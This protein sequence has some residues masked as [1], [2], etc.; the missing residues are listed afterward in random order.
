MFKNQ[1][2]VKTFGVGLIGFV[3]FNH[4][5]FNGLEVF[6]GWLG[7]WCAVDCKEVADEH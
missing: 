1:N 7:I 5:N 6:L 3:V 2:W 4:F